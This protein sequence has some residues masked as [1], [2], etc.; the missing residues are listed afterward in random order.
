MISLHA[1]IHFPREITDHF[2]S[3]EE[4]TKLIKDFQMTI[5]LVDCENGSQ[6]YFSKPEKDKFFE[7]L[8]VIEEIIGYFGTLSFEE[9]LHILFQD[10]NVKVLEKSKSICNY[11]VYQDNNGILDQ[12]FPSI[13]K[14]IADKNSTINKANEKQLI[15]NFL[16]DYYA[17][18]PI[19][20]IKSCPQMEAE[21]IN[22][23]HVKDFKELDAWLQNHRLKRSFNNHDTRHFENHPGSQIGSHGK[24][25]L[26]G[27]IGGRDNASNLLNSA[28]G[29]KKMNNDL[30]N[31]DNTNSAYIWYKY[32]N[33]NP[34]NQYHAYHL[35]AAFTHI[36]DEKAEEDIPNRIRLILDYREQIE[37]P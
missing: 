30:I 11:S 19:P 35:V 22:V 25:P 8:G 2:H 1:Y 24:S 14:H 12:N 5:D 7:D 23:P 32:E 21:L 6:I 9:S 36:R 27:G 13:I 34:Q 28:I 15:L 10:N 29:D 3:K 26:I 37:N 18:N 20:I 17:S 31:F 33:S 4:A 16:H